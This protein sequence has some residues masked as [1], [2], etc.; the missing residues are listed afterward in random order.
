MNRD[1]FKSI[2]HENYTV[3]FETPEMYVDNESRGR[4]GHMT[5][6][7]AEYKPGTREHHRLQRKLFLIPL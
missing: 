5:H 7:M 3:E 2:K 1:V 4:S 6:A